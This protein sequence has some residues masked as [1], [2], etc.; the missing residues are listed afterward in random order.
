MV[1]HGC[2]RPASEAGSSETKTRTQDGVG[3]EKP[4][5]VTLVYNFKTG[6]L[7]PHNSAIPLRAGVVETLVRLN[8]KL[9][10]TPW[11]AQTWTAK[12]DRTWIFTIRDGVTFQDGTKL[13]AT[14]VKASFERGIAAS[15]SLANTLKIATME[16][17]GQ[18]LTIVNSEPHP[19]LPSELV[20]PYAAII[21]VEAERKM[22]TA[23]FNH[24]P[25]GTGPFKVKQFA[26][27]IE[28]LLERYDEYWDG[29]AK[30]NEVVF[31]FNEDGNVRSLALQAKEADI[32][33]YIPAEMV[34]SVQQDDQLSVHSVESLRV[35]FLLYNNQ[36]PLLQHVKARKAIDLLLDR[37]SIAQEIM[38]G[39]A[40]PANGPFNTKLPFASIDAVRQL[41]IAEAK[42][43]LQEVGY[44]EESDGRLTKDGVPLTLELVTYKGR[45][46]LPLIAQL[47]QSDA[48]KAG[49][50][51]HV[52]TVEQVDTYLRENKTWDVATYS[53]LSAPRGDGGY[54]LNAALMPEGA[55]NAASIH[56]EKLIAEVK[57]LNATS[58]IK[59]RM[60]L[61]AEAVSIIKE[62]T[63]HSYAVYPNI[64]VGVNNRIINWRPTSEEYY[65]ITN[66]L[67]VKS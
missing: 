41:N 15:K 7:D 65:I 48:A 11:L 20:S 4:K 1:L 56:S 49:V 8:E 26:P 43:L 50:T 52:Q 53:N 34:E 5:R 35:H 19:S 37:E 6:L 14:A 25:V 62:E 21:N 45:P 67:D 36:N 27:N 10:V 51:I 2:S 16:A 66:K 9:E 63:L 31:K 59:R 44:K 13:D 17:K 28:I 64:I 29:Q 46:E 57:Q 47:L 55:L 3:G 40:K 58:D 54:F 38:L 23:A 42:R 32:A 30:L 24:A 18:Q 22:G 33:Y 61:T 12:N 60:Q 39:H